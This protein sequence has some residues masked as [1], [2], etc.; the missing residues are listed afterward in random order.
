MRK[1]FAAL[2]LISISA[3][4]ASAQAPDYVGQVKMAPD[5]RSP[6]TT[7]T[8]TETSW[9]NSGSAAIPGPHGTESW[10][11]S[12]SASS[13]TISD[14]LDA[15]L[16]KTSSGGT[17]DASLAFLHT[18][19]IWAK[20]KGTHL[21]TLN[22]TSS[23]SLSATPGSNFDK[24]AFLED[25]LSAITFD[26]TGVNGT[27]D[28]L[29]GG[30]S[31]ST[32]LTVVG[33]NNCGGSGTTTFSSWP[34]VTY[35]KLLPINY[36]PTGSSKGVDIYHGGTG[37]ADSSATVSISPAPPTYTNPVAAFTGPYVSGSVVTSLAKGSS[38]S[39]TN[40]SYDPDDQTTTPGV[41]ICTYAWT[42]N[43]EGAS[44][45]SYN[46]ANPSFT[47]NDPGHYTMQVTV[48]DNEVV[49]TTSSTV[50][51][52]VYGAR[53]ETSK[54]HSAPSRLSPTNCDPQFDMSVDLGTGNTD[55]DVLDPVTTRGYPLTNNIRV[56]SYR[57]YSGLLTAMG[58]AEFTYAMRL[59]PYAG[60]G[61]HMALID[62]GGPEYD[63][64]PVSGP[65][66]PEAGVFS[67]LATNTGGYLLSGAGAPGHANEAGNYTYQFD[68]TGLLQTITDPSSN[69]QQVNYSGGNPIGVDD[70]SSGRSI[71]FS[72]T[73]GKISSVT[74]AGG[75]VVT[76]L[77]YTSGLL[78]GIE[79]RD[80]SSTLLRSLAIAY[81]LDGTPT[82]VI[83]DGDSSTEV[84]FSYTDSGTGR[85]LADL[86]WAGSGGTHLNYFELPGTGATARTSSTDV[87][88]Q[89]TSYDYDSTGNLVR[90]VK[91]LLYGQSTATTVVM[92]YNSGRKLTS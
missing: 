16:N 21:V 71:S 3:H 42:L 80:A 46:I 86:S 47:M 7:T 68:G 83:R 58:N 50:S 55:I 51:F 59:I 9:S 34:G 36:G 70:L 8:Y 60:G 28:S 4:L 2:C 32:T 45:G 54:K 37:T 61:S 56:N 76:N 41:G 35:Y 12:G 52:L 13:G 43:R 85:R 90:I 15:N 79:E 5:P 81:N 49:Q 10:T 1:L 75:A 89:K 26:I 29:S 74:E 67:V 87:Q 11:Q 25:N 82:S 53:E 23:G 48:T 17:T 19:T 66:T 20:N 91:P 40:G 65:F 84:D 63:F 24:L 62:A 69:V 77:T 92:G 39:F 57:R 18:A 31:G 73:S 72:Y 78:T 88:G 44:Y 38:V 33:S 30:G 64:G 27:S 22:T 14:T 6:G